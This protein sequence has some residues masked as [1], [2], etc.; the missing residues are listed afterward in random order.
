MDHS[1]KA[2]LRALQMDLRDIQKRMEEIEGQIS[3][4]EADETK[5]SRTESTVEP[6]SV[7]ED[8]LSP[9][10]KVAVPEDEIT[11]R[12]DRFEQVSADSVP[13]TEAENGGHEPEQVPETEPEH[14]HIESLEPAARLE[15]EPGS[16]SVEWSEIQSRVEPKIPRIAEPE[17]GLSLPFVAGQLASRFVQSWIFGGNPIAKI[18]ILILFFMGSPALKALRDY[19]RQKKEGVTKYTF[20][21]EAL[22]I[23]NADFWKK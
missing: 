5:W 11:E 15:V 10:P 22:G 23:K 17:P 9:Q 18:G 19:E 6:Q 2:K 16:E 3:Q 1:L 4:E 8:S 7:A 21:P 14:P 20:D 13:F 12:S